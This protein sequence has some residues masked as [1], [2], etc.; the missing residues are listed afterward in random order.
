MSGHCP[1]R[2]PKALQEMQLA[3]FWKNNDLEFRLYILYHPRNPLQLTWIHMNWPQSC[4]M[5]RSK[6]QTFPN[7]QGVSFWYSDKSWLWFPFLFTLVKCLFFFLWVDVV[8]H[9]KQKSLHFL[10]F[11]FAVRPDW[12]SRFQTFLPSSCS[13]WT[14]WWHCPVSYICGFCS[15]LTTGCTTNNP[16]E[17]IKIDQHRGLDR[18]SPADSNSPWLSMSFSTYAQPNILLPSTVEWDR[19]VLCL[20]SSL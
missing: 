18:A 19:G 4:F 2:C 15:K 3:A 12:T 9:F 7:L 20:P 14:Q 5:W 17:I 10:I 6:L 8:S 16:S 11:P 1:S 13:L